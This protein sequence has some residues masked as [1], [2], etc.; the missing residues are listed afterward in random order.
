MTATFA[1]YAAV[2]VAL[3]TIIGGMLTYSYQRWTDRKHQLVEIRR[4]AYRAYLGALMDQI[5]APSAETL[6]RLHKCEFELFA[7]A[8]DLTIRKVAKFSSYMSATSFENKHKRDPILHKQQLAEVILAMRHDCFE[9]SR[10]SSEEA[11][12]LLPMQ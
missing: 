10:L 1:S 12:N 4:T 11:L 2:I 6:N 7:V 3:L 5:D 9:K 8:S